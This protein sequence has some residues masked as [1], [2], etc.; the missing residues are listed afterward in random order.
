MNLPGLNWIEQLA[1]RVLHCS[2]RIGLVIIKRY[3]SGLLSYSVSR[4][5]QKAV[6]MAQSL[7]DELEPPSLQLE[8][9][10]HLP[11]YGEQE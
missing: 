8:R 10:Y 11:S 1:L 5:D 2:P 4:D 9:L 3:Q 7:I 6:L